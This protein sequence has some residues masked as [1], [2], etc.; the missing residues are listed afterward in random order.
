M[1]PFVFGH[2]LLQTSVGPTLSRAVQALLATIVP[3]RN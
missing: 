1:T 3:E 2:T